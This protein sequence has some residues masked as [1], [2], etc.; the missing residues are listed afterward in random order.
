ME[1]IGKIAEGAAMVAGVTSKLS[2]LGGDYEVLVNKTGA[3]LLNSNLLWLGPIEFSAEEQEF[4]RRIQRAAGVSENGLIGAVQ[5]LEGQEREGGSTDVGDVSWVVPTLH[6][7]VTTAPQDVPWHS[8][9]VVAP[10]GMSIG[11]RGMIYAAKALA[12]TMVDLFED[13]RLRADIRGEFD[14]STRGHTFKPY[15]P[16]GPPRLPDR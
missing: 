1:R 14:R 6:L 12:A 13:E 16:D 11:H 9:A 10:G 2:I 8:W 5:P 15:I 3:R 4:A 7:S